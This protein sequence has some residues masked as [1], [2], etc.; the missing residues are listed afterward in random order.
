MNASRVT[1]ASRP[2]TPI[3]MEDETPPVRTEARTSTEVEDETPERFLRRHGSWTTTESDEDAIL[4]QVKDIPFT[5]ANIGES[6]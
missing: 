4:N 1:S 3:D 5:A 2:R 6:G